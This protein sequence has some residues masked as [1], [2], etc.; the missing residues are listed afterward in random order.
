MFINYIIENN[1]STLFIVTIGIIAFFGWRFLSKLIGINMLFTAF[2]LVLVISFIPFLPLNVIDVVI[3][4]GFYKLMLFITP[5]ALKIKK[6]FTN[7]NA[8]KTNYENI[9]F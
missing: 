2:L 1:P 5:Y 3:V 4:L 8:K 7:K 9:T 6:L